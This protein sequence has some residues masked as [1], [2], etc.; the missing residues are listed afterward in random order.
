MITLTRTQFFLILF[1]IQTGTVYIAFQTRLIRAAETNAWVV[2]LVAGAIHYLQLV[3]YEKVYER[4]NP[5]PFISWLYIGYWFVIVVTFLAY[6][7]YALAVWIFPDTPQ[8]IIIGVMVGVSL[9]ANLSRAATAINLPVLL[10]PLIPLLILALLFAIPDLEWTRLFPITFSDE[11]DWFKGLFAAQTTFIGVEIYLFLRKYVKKDS[12]IKGIPLFIYQNIWLFIFLT[13]LLFVQMFFPVRDAKIIEEPIIYILKSQK[14]TFVE[15]L[16][17]FFLFVWM[18]WSIVTITLYSFISI[19]VHQLHAKKKN[20]KRSTIIYHV[21]ICLV[22]LFFLT[23][24]RVDF[25]RSAIIYFHLFFSIVL[26]VVVVL[27][28]R[29][30]A[31]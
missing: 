17:L 26:P 8:I 29:R 3:L 9:Y 19:H 25:I 22:P 24:E 1:I 30:K 2:F 7:D 4:I 27:M 5:G 31:S 16:D 6:I 15:R 18:T 12:A 21:L 23:K 20:S 13:G 28:N 10:V 11:K 14:V